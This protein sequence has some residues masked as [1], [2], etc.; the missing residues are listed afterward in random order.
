[1]LATVVDFQD[2]FCLCKYHDYDNHRCYGYLN[3]AEIDDIKMPIYKKVSLGDKIEV[4]EMYE[5]RGDLILTSKGRFGKSFEERCEKYKKF[6]PV[7]VDIIK[8][9]IN[10]AIAKLENG[11]AAYVPGYFSVGDKILASVRRIDKKN[12]L[13]LLEYES[14]LI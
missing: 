13:I 12:Q 10:G 2:N 4:E 9:T 11:L 7:K 1:M 14:L 6:D 5:S 8:T 3:S